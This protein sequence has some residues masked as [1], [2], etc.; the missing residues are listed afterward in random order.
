M[1]DGHE[2]NMETP[3]IK[4]GSGISPIWILPLVA[5]CISGWLLYTSY[6]D[7]GIPITIHFDNAEGIAAGKTQVMYKGVPVGLVNDITVDDDLQGVNLQVTMEKKARRGIVEDTK[8]WVVRPEIS[9]GKISGLETILSGSYIG[10]QPGNSDQFSSRFEG[11]PEAPPLPADSPGLHITLQ[12][13]ALYSL[14]KDSPVY[15]RNLKIGKVLRYYL[16]EDRS[17]LID[18][19][20]EPEYSHLI[21]ADTRFWNSSGISFEGNL[22]SGFTLK[23][24]SL[25]A[26]VYGGISCG[27]PEPLVET[28]PRATNGLIYTLYPNYEAAEYWLPMTLELASGEGIIEGKTKVM[29]RGLEAGV[30]RKIR[31]RNNDKVTVTAE[32][33]LDPRAEPILKEG[34]RFWVRRPEVSLDGISDVSSLVSG[35][36]ITFI[37]GEGIFQDHFAVEREPMP[38]QIYREGTHYTLVSRESGFLEPGAPVL[39]NKVPV[40]EVYTVGF[41]PEQKNVRTEIVV[42]REYAHLVRANSVFWNSSGIRLEA[43]FSRFSLDLGTVK[44]LFKGG[45]SFTSPGEQSAHPAETAEEKASFELYPSLAEATK[46][47]PG[48][49]PPGMVVQLETTAEQYYETGSPLLYRKVPVGE[50]LGYRL[51][52]DVQKVIVDVLIHD[53]YKGLIN[54]SSLFYNSSG[55]RLEAGLD[56][57]EV[58]AGSFA[59]ILAGG[60]S[61][62]TPHQAEPVVDGHTFRLFSDYESAR[63]QENLSITLRMNGV[64]GVSRKT[65]IRYQGIEI[66]SITDLRFGPDLREVIA[67]A[68]VQKEMAPLFR[69]TSRLWLVRPSVGLEGVRNLSTVLTGPYISIAEGSGPPRIEFTLLPDAQGGGAGLNLVLE[70]P[71]LGFLGTGTPVYYRQVQVGQV[72]GY[73][74]SPTAQQIFVNVVIFKEYEKLVRS[75]TRFWLSSGIRASWGLFS[76]MKLDTESLEAI[77]SGGIAFATPDGDDHGEPVMDGD[78]FQLHDKEESGWSEWSPVLEISAA[79]RAVDK[80]RDSQ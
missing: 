71:R 31:I 32:I 29:Y 37:P 2:G 70:T 1:N 21:Q 34:T 22:R 80:A 73:N 53:K 6:R 69:E 58:E 11:L 77:L 3:V 50:V 14:Q 59:S 43:G 30:V 79:E 17:V 23:L 74:L 63:Q 40:G 65:K 39:F 36:Y 8:F 56:G 9:A 16:A 48:L 24:Q 78:H 27:T 44:S 64:E 25:A 26:L 20:V 15:S 10:V 18:L 66:G 76:G 54:G 46:T 49:H 62:V 12:S 13:E 4:K 41:D 68:S 61:F 45:V 35:P 75:T 51:G 67:T 72:T 60:I 33:L 57:V 38:R 55:W 7:A 42:Y 19:F 47:V 28:S 52:G 5:L